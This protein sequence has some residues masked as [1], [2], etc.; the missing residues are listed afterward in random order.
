[1]LT[2]T[3]TVQRALAVTITVSSYRNLNYKTNSGIGEAY[4]SI[5]KAT[6]SDCGNDNIYY[7]L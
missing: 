5:F 3:V 7:K 2:L 4:P 6:G 1:M